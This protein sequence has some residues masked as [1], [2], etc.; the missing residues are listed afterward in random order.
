MNFT[1]YH[2]RN[3]NGLPVQIAVVGIES[4][5]HRSMYFAESAEADI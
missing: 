5:T 2:Q 3:W 4:E 1:L